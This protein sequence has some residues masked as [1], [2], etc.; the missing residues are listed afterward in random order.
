MGHYAE[1]C[2]ATRS[3]P[4]TRHD[5]RRRFRGPSVIRCWRRAGKPSVPYRPFV[6]CRLW[7]FCSARFRAARIYP[8]H[9]GSLRDCPVCSLGHAVCIE[10]L[11]HHVRPR[12]PPAGVPLCP[13]FH[14]PRTCPDNPSPGCGGALAALRSSQRHAHIG[15]IR[16]D[17]ISVLATFTRSSRTAST[18]I[19]APPCATARSSG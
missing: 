2:I 14:A 13:R 7:L 17:R 12:A 4:S 5:R 3:R 16:H 11:P 8:T 1:I 10:S 19:P 15:P 18:T 9:S 6:H